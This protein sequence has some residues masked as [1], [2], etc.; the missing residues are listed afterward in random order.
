MKEEVEGLLKKGVSHERLQ[1][2]GLEYKFISQYLLKQINK[3][4]L[5]T[6]LS[7]AIHQ[8]AKRQ[9]TWYRRME[10]NGIE[11]EWVELGDVREIVNSWQ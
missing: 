9:M 5:F 6:L 4:E 8:F 3:K 11:I 1:F 7:T 10:K 2:L